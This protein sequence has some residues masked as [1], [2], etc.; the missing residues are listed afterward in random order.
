MSIG[1]ASRLATQ[2][3]AVV[4]ISGG[5]DTT[6]ADAAE[7]TSPLLLIGS[8]DDSSTP[9]TR[10]REI[11]KAATN[12]CSVTVREVPGDAH[13][14]AIF[15]GPSGESVLNDIVSFLDEHAAAN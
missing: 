2:P 9:M 14:S 4:D 5:N 12:A 7:L 1:A 8:A 15:D 11:E 6:P 3:S 10:L 13:A